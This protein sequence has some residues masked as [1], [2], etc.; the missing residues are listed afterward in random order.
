MKRRLSRMMA[1]ILA[2][3]LLGF[4]VAPPGAQAL[5]SISPDQL[6]VM[7]PIVLKLEGLTKNEL[8]RV[9]EIAEDK[10][11]YT[12]DD[13]V[14]MGKNFKKEDLIFLISVMRNPTIMTDDYWTLLLEG[15]KAEDAN[16]VL[17]GAQP[18]ITEI[19]K[20]PNAFTLISEVNNILSLAFEIAEDSLSI[21]NIQPVLSKIRM[22]PTS[23]ARALISLV[24]SKGKMALFNDYEK[25]VIRSYGVTK[26]DLL[27]AL[28]VIKGLSD[29]QIRIILDFSSSTSYSDLVN[30]YYGLVNQLTPAEKASFLSRTTQMIEL[31]AHL[32]KNMLD[33]LDALKEIKSSPL[34]VL[35][36]G[37]TDPMDQA[38]LEVVG[39][40]VTAFNRAV[41]GLTNAE[42]LLLADVATT[43][44]IVQYP[45]NMAE[46][47]D[48]LAAYK[49]QLTFINRL[50]NEQLQLLFKF[51]QRKYALTGYSLTPQE[52][53]ALGKMA[54]DEAARL[55][56]VFQSS[57]LEDIEFLRQGILGED[58]KRLLLFVLAYEGKI[59][60]DLKAGLSSKGI[61]LGKSAGIALAANQLTVDQLKAL[62]K[63]SS[64]SIDDVIKA[65]PVLSTDDEMMLNETGLTYTNLKAITTSMTTGEKDVLVDLIYNLQEKA[66]TVSGKVLL[67]HKPESMDLTGIKIQV[68]ETGTVIYSG[69]DGSYQLNLDAG[70]YTLYFSK[71]GHLSKKVMIEVVPGTSI[72]NVTLLAGDANTDN[73]IGLIDLTVFVD[74]YGLSRTTP[75]LRADFN[76]DI[77]VDS[78]DFGI[79]ASNYRLAGD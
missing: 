18:L 35:V 34:H 44:G 72:P 50:S 43:L 51:N 15:I 42:R 46:V 64:A 58:W 69:S 53:D 74:E 41:L 31:A 3:V 22:L 49:T 25:E 30:V 39:L 12:V 37:V 10:V 77:S 7:K 67:Q 66:S 9:L 26:D 60:S 75:V 47:L 4:F 79:L 55:L 68:L 78:L 33:E 6:R 1:G 48:Q 73:R 16:L 40:N 70:R 62:A 2:L 28:R 21:P 13:S 38:I 52:T 20:R 65:N 19:L 63:I 29:E 71:A 76:A 36:Y 54:K 8:R 23:Q 56:N 17:Q 57:T 32:S 45:N 61:G 24:E 27:V 14:F 11:R 5:I 59:P